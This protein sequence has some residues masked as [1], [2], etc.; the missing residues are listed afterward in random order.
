MILS[1]WVP[2]FPKL[3]LFHYVSVRCILA[4]LTSMFLSYKIYPHWILY[5]KAKK[6]GQPIRSL[7][8]EEEFTKKGTP[9]MGGVVIVLST[10]ISSILWGISTPYLWLIN[11]IALT[12]G[13]VGFADDY[14]KIKHKNSDGLSSIQKMIY[15]S[16]F[17]IVALCY[18]TWYK[19]FPNW[20]ITP[21]IENTV[22]VKSHMILPWDMLSI[23]FMKHIYIHLGFLFLPFCLVVLLGTSNGVNLTDGLDGLAIGPVM[24]VSI[25]FLVFAYCLGNAKVSEY[26]YFTYIP[27]IG[28]ISV[29]LSALL[30]AG[31]GFLWFNCYPAQIFM[32]DSGSL[33]L[34][35]ILGFTSIITQQE[36]ILPIAGCIF[37]LE[38]FSV[39][40][41]VFWYKR[42]KTRIFLMAP[43]HHHYQKKG[44]PE[45]KIIVRAWIISILLALLSLLTIK[46]R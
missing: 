36:L 28:E 35:G 27:N 7:G 44:Y 23:P 22:N 13:C 33:A 20:N 6:A 40:I 45:Q 2:F 29:F 37:V 1:L 38:S 4:L 21:F 24:A 9:S 12:F 17:S 11:F 18:L 41:Q 15:L 34:G 39:I 16:I 30:G 8:L 5:L 3:Q 14:L 10:C 19:H 46:V 26:L 32:G 43:L 31:L 25:V 42:T